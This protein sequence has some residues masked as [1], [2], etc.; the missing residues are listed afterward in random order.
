MN[1]QIEQLAYGSESAVH[2]LAPVSAGIDVEALSAHLTEVMLA[3]VY[4]DV[5]DPDLLRPLLAQ[6]T[7]EKLTGLAGLI[8]G[9]ITLDE[10]HAPAALAFAAEV[11]R[12]GIPEQQ[13]ERSYRVGTEALWDEW[14]VVVERHCEHTGEPLVELVRASIPIVF[15]FVDRM[16]FTSLASYHEA[17]AARHQTRE[18][19]RARLVAQLL[20]GTLADP[21][22]ETE[23]FIGYRLGQHHLAGVLD[24]GDRA[25]DRRLAGELKAAVGASELLVLDHGSAPTEFW[26]GLRGPLTQ[27]TLGAL[28]AQAAASGRRIAFG[29]AS[30]GLAGFRR[31]AAAA[32]DAARIQAMLADNALRVVWAEDVLIEILALGSPAGARGL[33]ERVLGRALEGDLLTARV[34]ETL[35]AWLV[36]GS[37]VSAAATLGVHEQTVRQRLRRL[38]EALGRSL[39][40]RR[41][42]LHV[43]LR[44]SRLTWAGRST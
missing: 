36:T 32:R 43:A 9:A 25:D 21:G 31:S 38:E 27:A 18:Y 2:D 4:S 26:L 44:L 11:G 15:G 19:R 20:D 8:A 10:L 41:T 42:E 6:A 28:H 3:E 22:I 13:L 35:E 29:E 30:P 34:Q 5:V 16:L 33:V 1:Q 40:D 14:M 12:Q 7:V 39:H 24:D 23:R 37:Y 17:V